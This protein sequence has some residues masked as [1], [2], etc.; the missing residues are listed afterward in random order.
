MKVRILLL[1]ASLIL[2]AALHA[3]TSRG[4]ITG[5][6]LDPAGAAIPGAQIGL[7]SVETG[8]RLSTKS[9]GRGVYRFDAVD[10]GLYELRVMHPG[11]RTYSGTRIGV[12][13]NRV[14][15][16]DPRLEIGDAET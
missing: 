2:A 5:T 1:A 11:F 6:V 8:I 14:T 12:E 9:N 13:A 16:V 3:Q 15:T 7:T 4:T 10:L